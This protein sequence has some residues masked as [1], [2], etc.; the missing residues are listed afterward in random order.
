MRRSEIGPDSGFCSSAFSMLAIRSSWPN[1]FS[2]KSG[3]S[4]LH[5]FHRHRNVPMSGDHNRRQGHLTDLSCASRPNHPF[6]AARRRSPGI[7]RS[8]REMRQ[9]TPHN[10]RRTQRSTHGLQEVLERFPYAGSSST[11]NMVGRDCPF[12][13]PSDCL[14]FVMAVGVARRPRLRVGVRSTQPACRG[15]CSQTAIVRRVCVEMS[16]VK[17]MAGISCWNFSRSLA[18][19]STPFGPF[20]RLKSATMMSGRSVKAIAATPSA[21]PNGDAGP[22]QKHL[23]KFANGRIILYHED[24]SVPLACK[25]FELCWV[26]TEATQV[27]ASIGTTILNM[28]PCPGHDFKSIECPSRLDNLCTIAKPSPSPL[29][30]SRAGLLI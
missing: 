19:T 11:T 14:G 25:P 27:G 7:L 20:G 6:P 3:G 8:R 22:R 26:G 1:G 18:M 4:G 21:A 16:P 23:E 29:L 12:P 24:R 17:T 28:E 15:A 9:G 5:R 2:M 30:R 13:A 10:S